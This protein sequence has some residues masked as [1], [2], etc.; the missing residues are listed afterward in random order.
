M[1]SL[2][3]GGIA[4]SNPAWTA[5]SKGLEMIAVEI[6]R[7]CH[8]ANRAYCLSLEDSSQS[9]WDDAPEWQQESAILGVKAHLK[10]NLNPEQSHELWMDEKI[11]QGWQWGS[12]KDPAKKEHPCIVPY[13]DLPVG[14]RRK[15]VL[16]SAVVEAL[17]CVI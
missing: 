12:V 11:Q 15:D 7:V 6:A 16:F 8:E 4:G 10:A 9:A 13:H 14:Q 5:K 3:T 2:W 1:L 17:S